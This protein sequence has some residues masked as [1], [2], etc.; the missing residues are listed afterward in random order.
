[1]NVLQL[2]MMAFAVL[3]SPEAFSQNQ[4]AASG[5]IIVSGQVDDEKNQPIVGVSIVLKGSIQGTTTDANGKFLLTIPSSGSTLVVSF[6]GYKRQEFDVGNKTS[7]QIK[8]EPSTD[9]LQEVVVV[10]YGTQRKQTLTGRASK[11]VGQIFSDR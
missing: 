5:D 10:G 7:F 6:L 4:S 9:E 2:V 1:M 8:L 11:S 3:F